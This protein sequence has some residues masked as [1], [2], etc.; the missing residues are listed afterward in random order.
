MGL[1]VHGKIRG[2]EGEMLALEGLGRSVEE[3]IGQR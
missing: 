1:K 2:I 3:L